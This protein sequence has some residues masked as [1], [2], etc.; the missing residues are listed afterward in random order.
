MNGPG[1]SYFLSLLFCVLCCSQLYAFDDIQNTASHIQQI[2]KIKHRVPLEEHHHMVK[3]EANQAFRLSIHYD[4][5]VETGLPEGTRTTIKNMIV[6]QLK[7]FL[8]SLL[9]VRPL[10]VPIL[11]DRDC[12]GGTFVFPSINSTLPCASTCKATT[13][14]GQAVVPMEHLKQ[15]IE[16]K[17]STQTTDCQ[18][19]DEEGDG[20]EDA[21]MILYV[22]AVNTSPCGTGSGG[23][24]TIAFASS[25]QMESALDRPI[26]GN[27]NFCPNIFATESAGNIFATAKH[28]VFHALAFSTSLY[29][30]WRDEQGEPRTERNEFGFPPNVSD[31][32]G[33]RFD[34]SNT[35]IMEFN[36]TDWEVFSGTVTHTVNLMVTPKV[37][38]HGRRHFGCSTLK[39]IEMENQGGPGTEL[40]HWEKRIFGNEIMTGVIDFGPVLSNVTLA[41]LEDSGWYR[42]NFSHGEFLE[43]GYGAGCTFASNS[44]FAYNRQSLSPFCNV[45]QA[46]NEL[47]CSVDR[48]S[49]SICNLKTDLG[50]SLP[51]E[52]RYFNNSRSG[53][54]LEIADYCPY[55]ANVRFDNGRT[56]DC[57]NATNQLPAGSNAFGERY[58]EGAACFTQPVPLTAPLS[59]SLG[60]GCFR[61]TCN[62]DNTK[63]AVFVNSVSYTCDQPGNVLN[64]MND[65]IVGTIQCPSSFEG[66]CQKSIDF[67]TTSPPTS[68]SPTPT[69]SSTTASTPSSGVAINFMKFL[70]LVPLF[71]AFL[72]VF[73]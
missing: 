56:G 22:S 36:Y 73:G 58:G 47:N 14:C 46:N 62:A 29:P 30:F 33:R 57:S 24:S 72:V 4:N 53:G 1:Q 23:P 17:N 6:P 55:Q 66:L 65:G 12:V 32:G 37:L 18:S 34:W 43:W 67:P 16:C 31:N 9:M 70:L 39:G 28:E 51:Q 7:T 71:T 44:C 50:L 63:L 3:R 40:S 64:V 38:E 45:P 11:L 68:S 20:I 49:I 61:Y 15:C 60:A 19:I 48:V 69:P 25:C 2:G 27:V 10:N 59:R 21:D 35:T 5:S 13:M 8:E 41:L 52:Y 42:V 54:Q 26:A